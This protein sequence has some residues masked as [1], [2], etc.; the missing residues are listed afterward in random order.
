[1]NYR[2]K[3]YIFSAVLTVI[4]IASFFVFGFKMGI[5]FKGGKEIIVSVSKPID[6]VRLAEELTPLLGDAPETK[7]FGSDKEIMVRTT[8]TDKESSDI[9]AGIIRTINTKNPG[10]NAKIIGS[11]N[12]GPRFAEDMRNGA[13][14]AVLLALLTIFVYILIRFDW[15]FGVG[16]VVAT[17]HDVIITMGMFSLLHQFTSLPLQIDQTIIA[18]FLT[19][20]GYS[21]NDTVIVFDRV[22]EYSG[23]YKTE[24]H[25]SLMNKAMNA[26]LSRTI[27]TS[28][29]VI[30]TA[31]VLFIVGG[32]VLRGFSFA[33]LVGLTFGTY[34][35]VYVASA[36]ALEL[37]LRNSATPSAATKK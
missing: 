29:T 13:I 1:M 4:S 34:S 36:V 11:D 33:M 26:T 35:S 20:V 17:F 27:I 10:A 30:L 32:E 15:R 23:I 2:K 24:P 8:V 28:A 21:V 6:T 7:T 14:T 22:R 37:R 3:A 19:I 18:A 25:V 12:V 31:L 5:D 16:A 9:E